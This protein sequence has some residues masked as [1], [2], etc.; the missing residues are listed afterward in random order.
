M[1]VTE[2]LSE[3]LKRG[4]TVNVPSATIETKRSAKL[5]EVGKTLRLPGFRPGKVP[6]KLVRQRYGQAVLGEVLEEAVN[7]ATTKLLEERNLRTVARP[8][9]ELVGAIADDKDLEFTVEVEVFPDFALPELSGI[10]LTKLV[11]ET[12]QD[13][14]DTALNEI[15]ERQKEL[16][17]V[18]EAR[19]AEQG[20]TV[21]VDFKGT[22]DDVAFDGGT[23]TDMAVEIGGKGFIPGFSEGLVGINVGETRNVDVTFPEEYH[24]KE[25]AG[26]PAVFELTAKKLQK[27]VVPELGDEFATKLG[28]ASLEKLRELVET[29]IK[30]EYDQL[31][32]LRLK[33]DLLDALA[34]QVDFPVPESM[35][36][37]EFGQIWQRLEADR[38]AGQL[39]EEDAG[40]D[41][42]TLKSEYRAIA[43]RRVRLGLL[44]AE[45][46]RVN[47]IAIQQEEM[48]RAVQAE[49]MKYRGQEREVYEFF[50][51]NPQAV[52]SLRGPIF[53]DKVVDFILELAK[54]ESKTVA[55]DELSIDP[56]EA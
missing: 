20:D 51:K 55:P 38:A 5:A 43:V 54:I 13:R 25:L 29:Q 3:G 12:P 30:R 6:A 7:D 52:E 39:D 19:A 4:Y 26:K 50:K 40:K 53:E 18:E 9:I 48:N 23:G 15:A 46:G 10:A 31:T 35:V 56:D 37:A 16:V 2:T 45:I 42:D 49:V 41:E 8:K 28:F 1:L 34:A 21:V 24:A 22:V 14:I 32:R 11:A 47:K 44:L 27:G 17:D 33:R 36:E